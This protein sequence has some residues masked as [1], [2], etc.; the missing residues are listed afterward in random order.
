VF[1]GESEVLLVELCCV[2]VEAADEWPER[3][4]EDETRRRMEARCEG[5]VG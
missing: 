1:G 4:C 5:C 2:A 3:E